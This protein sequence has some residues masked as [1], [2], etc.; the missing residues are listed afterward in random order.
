M[1]TMHTYFGVL[2]AAILVFNA[3]DDT[4]VESDEPDTTAPTVV[5]TS[6]VE[7]AT[8]SSATTIRVDANDD[9]GV[10]KVEFLIDGQTVATD[11]EEPWEHLW[12]VSYYADDETHSILAKATDEAENIG[13][14]DLVRVFV[15]ENAQETPTPI[16]PANGE[17]FTNTTVVNLTWSSI[18]GAEEY[19]VLVSSN[20]EFT[21]T[22]YSITTSDT[23]VTTDALADGYHYWKVRAKN[24]V[25]NYGE[26]SN[27][28]TFEI[29]GTVTDIDGNVYQTIIIGTQEWM[30]ENLKVTHYRDGEAIPTGHSNSEWSNLSTGAYCAYDNN[31]SNADTYGYLYNWY[32]VDDSRNIAPEGWHVPTDDEIKQLEMHLGMSQSEADDTGYRGTNEGSKLAGRADIWIDGNLENNSEFGTS[33]FTAL[34]GGYRYTNGYYYGMGYFGYF[35]SSTEDTSYC[36]WARILGFNNS[37]VYRY[38]YAKQSGFSVRCLRD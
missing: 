32:A 3:C 22:E 25:G 8:L 14:S 12:Q 10:E 4:V 26:W 37:G 7:D 16:S 34:P 30:A 31:E 2:I 13:Q 1:K 5:I 33:G 23:T 9:T 17:I 28:F 27:Y 24:S 21:D 15:S 20:S 19:I 6:P 18:A 35:W 29:R 36:A 38:N 11:T